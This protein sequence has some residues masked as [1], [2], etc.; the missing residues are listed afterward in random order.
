MA[1]K[2]LFA[3]PTK[4]ELEAIKSQQEALFAPPTKEELASIQEKPSAFS[5]SGR[6]L[7]KGAVEALP[8][9]GGLAGGAIGTVGMP[10]AGTIAGAGLGAAAGESLRRFVTPYLPGEEGYKTGL[11]APTNVNEAKESAKNVGEGLLASGKAGAEMATAEA[12]GQA[13]SGLVNKLLAVKGA[14]AAKEG[15]E[16]IMAA[17]KRLG[18]KP[19][20]G[21]KTKDML[22]TGM[23]SSLEQSPSIAGQAV[24]SET[25]PVKKGLQSTVEGL[26]EEATP[27]T[28]RASVGGEIKKGIEAK[29]GEKYAPIKDAYS[30]LESHMSSI[31]VPD[32]AKKAATRAITNSDAAAMN[33]G[34]ADKFTS[35]LNRATNLNQIKLVRSDAI[36]VSLS[37]T[38]SASEKAIASDVIGAA[39]RMTERQATRSAIEIAG[40]KG[41][42]KEIAKGMLQQ[43]KTTNDAYKA[44]KTDLMFISQ[45]AGL[46]RGA[47]YGPD[48]FVKQLTRDVTPEEL[49]KK[50]FD[51]KDTELLGKFKEMFPDQYEHAR[52]LRLGE[53]V[54]ASKNV[55]GEIQV[56]SFLKQLK[57]LSSQSVEHLF[58]GDKSQ[59]IKDIQTISQSLPDKIG[60]SGT[61]QGIQF[62][63]IISNP[64]QEVR[65]GLRYMAYKHRSGL[66]GKPIKQLTPGL[67]PA[68]SQGAGGLLIENQNGR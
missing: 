66:I 13:V 59:V 34:F 1:D 23:E 55:K 51:A 12:G 61:P 26:L 35:Q 62:M 19:T 48:T 39:D 50:L 17:G 42:G 2:D 65:E 18:V 14:P 52:K 43:R 36:A 67:I 64:A 7:L 45:R 47:E 20:A 37:D 22:T 46:G 28:Q 57:G 10:G 11:G 56:S 68:A 53:I 63:N 21:M 25:M 4:E 6:G 49:P 9:A 58:G 5:L 8:M 15:V 54:D 24:R 27:T 30:D 32:S 44:L 31:S 38:A 3:P 41:G 16:E 29:V 60:Q 33:P 40:E